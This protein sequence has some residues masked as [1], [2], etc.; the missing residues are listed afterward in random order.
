MSQSETT[1]MAELLELDAQVLQSYLAELVDWL[2]DLSDGAPA[3]I[4]DLGSGTGTGTLA[5]AQRFPRAHVTAV[6]LSPQ[7]LHR[8]TEKASALG[9]AGRVR[10][11]RADL[12]QGWPR[13]GTSDLVWAASSLHHMADPGRVLAGA[14]DHLRPGGLLAVTEMSFFPRFLPDDIGV[15]RPGLEA[16]VH[17][18][19]DSGPSV[20]WSPHLERA[21]FRLEAA[22]PF[23]IDLR[24][25]LPPATARY[26]QVCLRKL[27][28]HL[29]REFAADDLAALDAVLDDDS[30]HSVLR[31]TDLT[32][33]TV[34]T[35]WAARRP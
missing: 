7:M 29:G 4:V 6:D 24:G 32:V 31:R 33:R 34:R 17:A 8:L 13:T 28:S 23:A 22:R 27:R 9:L 12:D 16:R 30:P 1:A 3:R 19:L 15:G 18:A 25:S 20:D 35:T 26:A 2:G 21:G 5:L 11:L 10:G 14:F